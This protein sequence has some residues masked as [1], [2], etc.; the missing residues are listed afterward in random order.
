MNK[1]KDFDDNI[2][3]IQEVLKIVNSVW[4]NL[5]HDFY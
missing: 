4:I 1:D 3:K 2:Y 5:N